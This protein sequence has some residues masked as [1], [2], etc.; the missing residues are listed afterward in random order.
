MHARA[1]GAAW[2][3]VTRANEGALLVG[4]AGIHETPVQP[5]DAV[6]T[7]GAGDTFIAYVLVGLLGQKHPHSILTMA[8]KA[9]ADTCLV[10]GAFGHGIPMAVNL[11]DMM[12]LDEIYRTTHP[13][14]A[15]S[16]A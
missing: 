11:S 2:S 12:G 15:P 4:E 9:A 16:D 1:S 8:A 13:A 10:R 14:P 5:V 6:D 7:L 3:L